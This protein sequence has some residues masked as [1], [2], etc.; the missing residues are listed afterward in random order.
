MRVETVHPPGK[1]TK[2]AY[3]ISGILHAAPFFRYGCP[4]PA[5]YDLA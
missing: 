3:I 4:F 1:N 5:P 2:S